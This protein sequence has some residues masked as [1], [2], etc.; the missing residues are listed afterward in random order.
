M[1]P[2]LRSLRYTLVFTGG[3][4]GTVA[5][6]ANNIQVSSGVLTA[7]TPTNMAV[8]FN[9]SWENSWRAE[10]DRW[11]AAW[12]FV[13]YRTYGG[14]WR[15]ASLDNTGH[16]A[17]SGSTITTGLLT[18]GTAYNATTNPGVGA[19]IYR[20]TTGSGTFTANGAQLRWNYSADNISAIDVQEVRVFA[21][22][23]VYVPQG[24]FWL[25]TGGTEDWH[26]TNGSTND[27][28]LISSE[29]AIQTGLV[30]TPLGVLTAQ[31]Y[32]ANGTLASAF[33]KGFTAFYCM[34]YELTQQAYADFLSTLTYAQQVTRTTTAPNSTAGSGALIL[35]GAGRNGIDIQTPGVASTTPA[36]YACNLDG[37]ASYGETVDGT[38]IAC[39]YLS[40]G[41][42]T[43]YL[44]WSGLRPMTELEFEKAC[45]GTALPLAD[46][47]P[48]G[49]T[50]IA[51]DDY[52]LNNVGTTNEGIATNYSLTLGNA[53][54]TTTIT[55]PGGPRRVGI[56]SAN[57]GNNGRVTAG[58]TF[59]G[60]MEMAGNM[61][62]RVVSISAEGRVFN[63]LHGN[64]GLGI[65]GN[66]DVAN[67]LSPTTGLGSGARGGTYSTIPLSLQVSDRD[68]A[69]KPTLT[70][71]NV[72]H[73]GRGVRSAP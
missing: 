54:Y 2:S 27:P 1:H 72:T 20:S 53:L 65:S 46:E 15:H 58:A 52:T 11:D 32:N 59:Y 24:A 34:K 71:R 33:P 36:I 42:L 30:S 37:D 18:P 63:G 8:E 13:K 28:Y 5:G 40:W 12:V 55:S 56:F 44:D 64:G 61:G 9:V 49:T 60:I 10:P 7:I 73:G 67:W 35:S 43:G 62:D 19:F 45:R 48:W 31:V 57:S 68:S 39:N 22:E 23:M 21:I 25:G 70:A 14:E 17:P 50:S 16:V 69:A 3:L 47:Y 38:D 29:A 26:F 66:P 51:A 41:D 6:H 4:L